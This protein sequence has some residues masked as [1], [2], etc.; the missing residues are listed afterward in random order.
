VELITACLLVILYLHFKSWELF[1]CYSILICGFII[2]TF[3]DLSHRIIPDEVSLGL[4]CVGL[5]VS[6]IFPNLHSVNEHW[7]SLLRSFTGMIAG[8]GSIFLLGVMGKL[9]FRKESMGGGDVKFFAMAGSFL[10]WELI[11]LAFFIAPFFGSIF[12]ITKK[13]LYKEEYIPY[14]P[15]LA[16]GC[17][18]SLF[19]GHKILNWILVRP[20]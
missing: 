5:I 7:F 8:G 9:I 3:T 14:A 11:L 18:I 13:L 4:L 17:L 6:F 19:W 2:S 16:L 15:F 20:Y 10:G 12:G 1:F